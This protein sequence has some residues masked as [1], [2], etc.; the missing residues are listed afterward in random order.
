[1]GV[2]AFVEAEKMLWRSNVPMVFYYMV[3]H[4]QPWRCLKQFGSK[5]EFPLIGFEHTTRELHE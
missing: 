1:L 4:H 3:E 5:Q 2:L